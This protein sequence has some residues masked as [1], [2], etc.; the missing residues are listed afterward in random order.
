MT[1]MPSE[2][3]LDARWGQSD[4]TYKILLHDPIFWRRTSKGATLTSEMGSEAP[5]RA[6]ECRRSRKI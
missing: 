3:C 2:D 1:A 6:E 4:A 5:F